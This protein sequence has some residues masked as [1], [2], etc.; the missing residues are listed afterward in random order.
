MTTITERIAKYRD[1][2]LYYRQQRA[3][4]QAAIDHLQRPAIEESPAFPFLGYD[5]SA[6]GCVRIVA[7]ASPGMWR[8]GDGHVIAKV[9][10]TREIPKAA[11]VEFIQQRMEDAVDL[12]DTQAGALEREG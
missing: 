12:R 11:Y 9:D 1:D 8:M 3:A 4:W 6:K 10:V 2:S 7:E 5:L